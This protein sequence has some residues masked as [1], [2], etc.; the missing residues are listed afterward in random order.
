MAEWRMT[1][2]YFKSCSCDPG[3]PCDFMSEPT[4]HEC[5]GI[6]GMEVK[7]GNFDGVSL[8]GVKWAVAYQWPG[9]LHEGNGTVKAYFDTSTSEEQLNAMGQILTGQ[10]GGTWF[11]VVASI[12]SEMKD[13]AVVPL[14]FE[15]SDRSGTIKIGDVIENT[16]NPIKNPVTGEEETVLVKIPGGMEYSQ[17]DGEAQVV[18]SETLR[19]TD[20]IAFDH[21]GS[22]TSWVEEQT[23]GSHR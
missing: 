7:E 10:A 4:H 20:E 22:H 21:Q 19:S 2:P 16:Y 14:D 11:E 13:P 3:C 15:F 17:N 6:L 12:V 18:R 9:P 5:E 8:D 23:F 1:G